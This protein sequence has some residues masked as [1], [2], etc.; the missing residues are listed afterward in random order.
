MTLGDGFLDVT[1]FQHLLNGPS[2]IS[3]RNGIEPTTFP[4]QLDLPRLHRLQIAPGRYLQNVRA[5]LTWDGADW[6]A[7]KVSG[8]VPDELIQPH[9]GKSSNS[10]RD[11]TT[12]DF[13]YLPTAPQPPHLSLRTNDIGA[14]LRALNLYDN[15]IDGNVVLTGHINQDSTGITTKLQADQFTVRKAPIIAH[16]LAAASLHGLKNLLSHDGLKFAALNADIAW[17][18]DR[19]N[20]TRAEAHGGSLGVTAQGDITYP[21]GGLELRG[22][23]IPA[24]LLNSILGQVPVVNLLV[25]GKGQG[26]VAVNYHLTGKL[27]KPHVSV[28]PISALTPGFL[29]GVFRLFKPNKAEGTQPSPPIPTFEGESQANEP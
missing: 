9:Y 23:I 5:Y 8:H 26:L 20:I 7:I 27:A 17:Y 22:T 10:S 19:L 15:L 3:T 18:G 28:N 11:A 6:R 16:L 2:T 24:Y 14:V 13:L 12:F 4:V 29:R 21:T 1:P 25:G